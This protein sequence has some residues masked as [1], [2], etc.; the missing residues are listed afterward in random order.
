MSL[1]LFSTYFFG[2][3]ENS[4]LKFG[5]FDDDEEETHVI[6]RKINTNDLQASD[7]KIDSLSKGNRLVKS[8]LPFR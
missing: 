7:L 5:W 2:C 8:T 4:F 6:D 1:L 3:V